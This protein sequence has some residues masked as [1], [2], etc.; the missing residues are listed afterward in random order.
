MESFFI[1][2]NPEAFGFDFLFLYSDHETSRA[3]KKIFKVAKNINVCSN[4]I[5]NYYEDI[6]FDV[7]DVQEDNPNTPM[8]TANTSSYDH[9]TKGTVRFLESKWIE[10]NCKKLF[11]QSLTQNVNIALP[12]PNFTKTSILAEMIYLGRIH[13]THVY[14]FTCKQAIEQKF[15]NAIMTKKTN[16]TTK[17]F[18]FMYDDIISK[19]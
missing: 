2:Y 9:E 7:K 11:I 6:P 10:V 19:K 1:T 14:K 17:S 4:V 13:Y 18:T 15:C 16:S 12:I 3:T 8:V 5:H